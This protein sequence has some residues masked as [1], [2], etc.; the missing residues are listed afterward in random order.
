MRL[1]AFSHNEGRDLERQAAVVGG[2]GEG[3]RAIVVGS[4]FVG[5]QGD[6]VDSR[7]RPVD[8]AFA[9][10]A[11]VEDSGLGGFERVT[12]SVRFDDFGNRMD[13]GEDRRAVP[14]G[15]RAGGPGT[16][17]GKAAHAEWREWLKPWFETAG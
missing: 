17:G 8:V 13:L 14:R 12:R 15:C 10:S 6:V 4:G 7:N 3:H 2:I 5:Q 1:G 16:G 11:E 9:L